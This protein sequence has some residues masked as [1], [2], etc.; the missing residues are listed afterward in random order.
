MLP[1]EAGC[2]TRS[3]GDFELGRAGVGDDLPDFNFV[4]FTLSF[5]RL[6]S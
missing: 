2:E 5:L 4:H 6:V 1:G 3:I